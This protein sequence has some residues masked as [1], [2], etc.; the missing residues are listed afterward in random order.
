MALPESL[1]QLVTLL[2]RL[3]GVGE[4]SARRMAFYIIQQ[5]ASFSEELAASLHGLKD[6]L[7]ECSQCG[8]ITDVDPCAICTDPF[9]EKNILCVVES[10]E[11]LLS[12]EQ[13]GIYNGLYHVLRGKIS[14]L[15]GEDLP[16]SEYERLRERIIRTRVQEVII[17]T[18]PRVEGDLTFYSL[19]PELENLDIKISRLA[20]GLPVGGSIEFAD[21]ITLHAAFE[22][23]VDV[24][25][26][27]NKR[28]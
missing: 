24:K 16:P 20:Y 12:M 13:A 26:S 28:R 2:K 14:P 5:P 1:L 19:L 9:R 27:I 6:R 7:Y 4:K 25:K 15:D 11:D 22:S 17:A 21:R 10:A 23:R 3:P 8:N 18:N